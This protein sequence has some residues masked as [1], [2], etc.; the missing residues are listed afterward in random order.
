V[1][2]LDAAPFNPAGAVWQPISPSLASARRLIAS[3]TC[4]LLL[5]AL[6]VTALLTHPLVWAAT[7]V[8]VALWLWLLWLIPRQVRAISYAELPDEFL[9]RRGVLNR[10]LTAV[11]YGRMQYV[12]VKVGPIARAYRIAELQMH[13]AAAGLDV[14]VPGLPADEAERLRAALAALGQSRSAG[15]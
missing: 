12:D 14:S 6:A 3:I 2:D 4:T 9:V 8:P 13:T 10:S 7:A 5:I 11:P 15:L 1:R